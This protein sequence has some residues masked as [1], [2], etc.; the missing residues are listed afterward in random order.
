MMDIILNGAGKRQWPDRGFSVQHDSLGR[1]KTTILET[2]DA[3][4]NEL[5]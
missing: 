4:A 3:V 2:P 5:H 1:E